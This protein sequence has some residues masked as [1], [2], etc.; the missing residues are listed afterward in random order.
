MPEMDGF[1][2]TR[3]IRQTEEE[4][5]YH[6]PIIAM[7]AQAMSGDR[8]A[9]LAAGMDDY[10]SKPVTSAKLKEVLDRWLPQS[11]FAPPQSG[12]KNSPAKSLSRLAVSLPENAEQLALSNENHPSE[13][14]PVSQPTFADP[15]EEC[16]A[17][18]SESA[19]QHYKERLADWENSMGRDTA[20]ELMSE[21]TQG[22]EN[23]IDELH[24][25]LSIGS[26]VEARAAA[27][28]VERTLLELPQ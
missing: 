23:T 12:A 19:I 7:T 3:A 6:V 28:R 14:H 18:L 25:L 11:A 2:A 22:I 17:A 15:A 20:M 9:C 1:E 13:Q 5:G 26:I 4:T 21:F 8:E 10:V 24:T 16:Q 27:H